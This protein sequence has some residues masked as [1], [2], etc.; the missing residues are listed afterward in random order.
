MIFSLALVFAPKI[1]TITKIVII[2]FNGGVSIPTFFTLRMQI[3]QTNKLNLDIEAIDKE[4]NKEQITNFVGLLELQKYIN[5][6]LILWKFYD[7]RASEI[8]TFAHRLNNW[9]DKYPTFITP[10]NLIAEEFIEDYNGLLNLLEKLDPNIQKIVLSYVYDV[11]EEYQ[12]A[13]K[14]LGGGAE[15]DKKIVEL[16][17]WKVKGKWIYLCTWIETILKEFRTETY[18]E[19]TNKDNWTNI[20]PK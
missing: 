10:I 6:S 8:N 9:K 19:F 14:K 12:K 17:N 16:L 13:M 15:E 2:A 5:S 11:C 7:T 4:K 18:I 1:D 20:S 3:K